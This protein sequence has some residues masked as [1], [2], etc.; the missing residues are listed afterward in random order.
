MHYLASPEP[1]GTIVRPDVPSVNEVNAGRQGLKPLP[2]IAA[3]LRDAPGGA[4]SRFSP[5][6]SRSD[7]TIVDVDFSP[8]TAAILRRYCDAILLMPSPGHS[9]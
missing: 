5:R 7:G 3:S 4:R 1:L 2:T 8:R 6:E 9:A